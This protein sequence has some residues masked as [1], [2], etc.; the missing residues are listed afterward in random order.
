MLCVA[1]RAGR[2]PLGGAVSARARDRL[3]KIML[4]A[5]VP[6]SS[7]EWADDIENEGIVVLGT[8]TAC[9]PQEKDGQTLSKSD[10]A[11]WGRLQYQEANSEHQLLPSPTKNS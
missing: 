6:F 7:I 9:L 5:S 2:E 11:I 3:K 4:S 10:G 8:R 1:W